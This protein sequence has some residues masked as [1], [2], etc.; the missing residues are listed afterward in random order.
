MPSA[1][2]RAAIVVAASVVMASA[3]GA[4]TELEVPTECF[5][6]DLASAEIA[7]LDAF[8]MLDSSGSMDFP[9]PGASTRWTGTGGPG[10]IRP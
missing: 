2:P 1:F 6:R 8:I 4:R 7:Q 10:H 3:C 5:H 9:V